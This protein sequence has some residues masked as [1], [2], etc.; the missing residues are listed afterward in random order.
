RDVVRGE[1]ATTTATASG[2]FS[3]PYN[4]P[5][6]R[7]QTLFGRDADID[8]VLDLL[9]PGRSVRVAASVEGL[10]GVGK[11]ELALHLVDRLS[12][13]DRFPGGIF[14][15]DAEN[16]D[17]TAVWGGVIADALAVGPGTLDERAAAAVRL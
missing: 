14:W 17:L 11:T 8:H 2:V 13:T 16:P 15:F 10:A 1:R 4:L 3:R 6:R 7:V 9:V 5:A 12:E